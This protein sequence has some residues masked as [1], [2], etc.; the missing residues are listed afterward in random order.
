MS[1]IENGFDWTKI[2]DESVDA[3]PEPPTVPEGHWV[4]KAKSAKLDKTKGVVNVALS[5]VSPM[6]DVDE[7]KVA[8]FNG[9]LATATVFTRFNLSRHDD[10]SRLKALIRGAGLGEYGL[11]DAFKAFKGANLAGEIVHT[12]KDDGTQGV[13]VNVRKLG[14]YAG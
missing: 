11:E 13:Y 3:W 14:A 7:A 1:N 12:P 2:V 4:M 5:L 6:D 9:E 8:A 10:V